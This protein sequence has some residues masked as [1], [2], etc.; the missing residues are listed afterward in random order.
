MAWL[1]MVRFE[2]FNDGLN[3]L[4][5]ALFDLLDHGSASVALVWVYD[6]WR[7]LTWLQ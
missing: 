4:A 2:V 5:L 1:G 7:H 6:V 3:M